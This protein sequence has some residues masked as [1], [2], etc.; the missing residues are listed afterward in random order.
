[1]DK[2]TASYEKRMQKAIEALQRELSTIR[3]GKASPSHFFWGSF[4]LAV[5]RFSGH[6][7]W[8]DEYQAPDHMWL[9]MDHA[10]GAHTMVE[11]SYSYHHT[12]KKALSEFVY[13]LIGTEGVI[14][15]GVQ[16]FFVIDIDMQIAAVEERIT[17]TGSGGG[18]VRCTRSERKRPVRTVTAAVPGGTRTRG[19]F[20]RGVRAPGGSAR[21]ISGSGGT[22]SK[23]CWSGPRSWA[24]TAW[25]SP[26][27]TPWSMD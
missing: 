12:S 4:D 27:W 6:G 21:R 9:H 14:E 22:F 16:E 1:M 23:I 15:V 19:A 7:A 24:W 10:N 11:M 18:F 5:T 25:P 2:E 8:V 3:A 17:V 13:E 20:S 26:T